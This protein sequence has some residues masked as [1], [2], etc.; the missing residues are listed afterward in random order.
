MH[1]RTH[2]RTHTRSYTRT[3]AL[4]HARTRAR[5]QG[6]HCEGLLGEK[7]CET[8]DAGLKCKWDYTLKECV[9][10]N[11]HAYDRKPD[12]CS[13]VA[14]CLGH[15]RS[16]RHYGGTKHHANGSVCPSFHMTTHTSVHTYAHKCA[17]DFAWRW[18]R[19]NV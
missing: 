7:W 16:P 4:V 19:D 10:L 18:A 12:M 9:H 11:C 8:N 1:A 5:A 3:L 14:H 15:E 13:K 2:A 17:G 6:K